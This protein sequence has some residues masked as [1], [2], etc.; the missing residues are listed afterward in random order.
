MTTKENIIE[1]CAQAWD[2]TREDIMGK[3]RQINIAEARH[4]SRWYMYIRLGMTCVEIADYFGCTHAAV[5]NSIHRVW[6]WDKPG[7]YY[8][9][10]MMNIVKGILKGGNHE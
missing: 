10:K 3:S 6:E 9:K 2:V 1:A 4:Y 7:Y 5:L 8:Q